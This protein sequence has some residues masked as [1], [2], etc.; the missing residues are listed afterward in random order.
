M[1]LYSIM[2]SKEELTREETIRA[3]HLLKALER[4]NDAFEFKYP[5]DYVGLEIPDYPEIVKC[6]MDLS[7]VRKNLK[8]G[9]YSTLSDFMMDL[10]LIW[11]NC[12]LY[13]PSDSVLFI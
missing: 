1:I 13:N 10:Q 9:E 2:Q 4:H 12:K 11:D 8:A 7:T 6:P 3:S 5:V